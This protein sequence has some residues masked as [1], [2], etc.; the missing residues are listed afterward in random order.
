M[1]AGCFSA[2]SQTKTCAFKDESFH[3]YKRSKD[4][5]TVLLSA[6][7][8]GSENMPFLVTGRGGGGG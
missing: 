3:G 4:G 6:N 2:Y 8:D 1:S 5:I 7:T